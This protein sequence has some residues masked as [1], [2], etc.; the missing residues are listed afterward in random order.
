MNFM[1]QIDE[2]YFIIGVKKY[3]NRIDFH[4]FHGGKFLPCQI[5]SIVCPIYY[6]KRLQS[7][8]M[9]QE[10][11][12]CMQCAGKHQSLAVHVCILKCSQ[13]ENRLAR[14]LR[15]Q[16]LLG[17]C[18][19][20]RPWGQLGLSLACNWV[21]QEEEECIAHCRVLQWKHLSFRP[22]RIPILLH[23]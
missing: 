18:C 22:Q 9:N 11:M 7:L 3:T 19:Q 5:I 1:Q 8:E 10:V 21:N 14:A 4:H 15:Y 17:G 23:H 13:K 20:T 6:R 2:I 16:S 12:G